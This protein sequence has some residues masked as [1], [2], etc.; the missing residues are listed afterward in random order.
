ML[1]AAVACGIPAPALLR[2]ATVE[3]QAFLELAVEAARFNSERDEALAR[4]VV[5]ALSEAM[6]RGR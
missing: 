4:R 3:R 6:K 5:N 1:G 2:A